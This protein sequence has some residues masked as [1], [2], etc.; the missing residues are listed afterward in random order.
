MYQRSF[1][2]AGSSN[3]S[4]IIVYNR[5]AQ[6]A[7]TCRRTLTLTT[8]NMN[9]RI[10]NKHGL[11][12]LQ[13]E[14][15]VKE[16]SLHEIAIELARLPVTEEKYVL[17][18]CGNLRKLIFSSVGFSGFV[19]HLLHFRSMRATITLIGCDSTAHRLL[20]LLKVAHMFYFA[21]TMDD[22]Y[23]HLQQAFRPQHDSNTI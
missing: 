9:L 7:S 8:D 1:Q 2:R 10:D 5:K 11:H 15:T 17:L 23:L 18:D 22:A 16:S 20:K 19:S 12:L 21:P 3:F 4:L 14:G 6:P 13:V